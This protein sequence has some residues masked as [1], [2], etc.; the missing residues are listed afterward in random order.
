MTEV[1]QALRFYS[2]RRGPLRC[3]SNFYPSPF[4]LDGM[5]WPTVEHFFQAMKFRNATRR[6]QI[7]LSADPAEAKRLGRLLGS[8]P[9]WEWIRDDVMLGALRATFTQLS[10]LRA[11]LV[12][13]GTA[14][15]IEAAPDD[16]YWGEGADRVGKNMLGL[17][18]M[19]VRAELS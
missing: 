9:D 18:L 8:R 3:L 17:L 12:G 11:V 6:E 13:T 19:Q 1:V 10:E 15:L 4:A 14:M 7:R 16:Y 5:T 2:H